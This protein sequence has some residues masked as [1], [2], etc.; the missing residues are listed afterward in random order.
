MES[1]HMTPPE[2]F[3]LGRKIEAPNAEGWQVRVVPNK[4]PAFS[5]DY[6]GFRR[7]RKPY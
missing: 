6:E 1:E 2:V 7:H 4:F 3:A 5:L